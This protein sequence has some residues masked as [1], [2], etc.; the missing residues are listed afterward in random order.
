ML[1][2]FLSECIIK[3]MSTYPKD[4][5][6]TYSRNRQKYTSTDQ[7]LFEVLSEITLKDKTVL[8][9]GC[10]DGSY[11]F[12]F[13]QHDTKQV[14]GFDISQEMIAIA[15]N[16]LAIYK[17][18]ARIQFIVGDGNSLPYADNTFD[19]VVA[20]F[21]LVHFDDL[22]KYL[23]EVRRV[24]KDGGYFVATINCADVDGVRPASVRLGNDANVIMKV[25]LRSDASLQA[26]LNAEG[27]TIMEY[28][29]I[30]NADAS[31]MDS[32]V[33]NFHGVLLSA[34]K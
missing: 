25:F 1:C 34:K 5:T 17:K 24:L 14:F 18:D 9:Y 7:Y 12:M 27:F 19:I 32:G 20:N 10:G 26:D 22:Q 8:D 28:K 29:I 16:K 31:V 21:V 6:E 15:H 2:L 11:S 13:E 30:N 4:L 23:Q 3:P 33:T